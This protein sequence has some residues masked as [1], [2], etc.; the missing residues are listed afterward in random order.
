M[1]LI[2]VLALALTQPVIAQQVTPFEQKQ[3]SFIGNAVPDVMFERSRPSLQRVICQRGLADG[4][5]P[6][7][8]GCGPD[9]SL[10]AGWFDEHS[11]LR[12]LDTENNRTD[13][14]M[15]EALG[16]LTSTGI[17]NSQMTQVCSGVYLGA[18]HGLLQRGDTEESLL[19]ERR[20][21]IDAYPFGT[22]PEMFG[23]EVISPRLNTSADEVWSDPSTDWAFLRVANP[24]NPNSYAPVMNEF[25]YQLLIQEAH[26]NRTVMYRPQTAFSD[27][28]VTQEG[29]LRPNFESRILHYNGDRPELMERY[30]QL[31]RSTQ[32]CGIAD[33][34]R[35]Y[36][37][38]HYCPTEKRISGSPMII[39]GNDAQPYVVGVHVLGK[40]AH[41]D[42]SQSLNA[43]VSSP[44]FCQGYEQVCGQPCVT[45]DDLDL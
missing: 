44:A 36:M 9:Q 37:A 28:E 13:Q 40:E 19:S 3:H 2:I 26:G 30:Q 23:Y 41:H 39:F 42:K 14:I 18:A 6:D 34:G 22:K 20:P 16:T 11:G 38:T 10:N 4:Y 15:S 24:A 35:P 27:V 7:E 1:R 32:S 12:L 17:N 29:I 21:R 5:S 25:V 33:S 43:F 45:L 31:L 8:L